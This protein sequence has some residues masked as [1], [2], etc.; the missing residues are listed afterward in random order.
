MQ[1]TLELP[2]HFPHARDA[3]HCL[4]LHSD[5]LGFQARDILTSEKSTKPA[6]LI[7]VIYQPPQPLP[8]HS[9]IRKVNIPAQGSSHTL[10]MKEKQAGVS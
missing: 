6:V 9:L 3:T 4:Q 1:P 10:K 2:Q 5:G 7:R 8:N